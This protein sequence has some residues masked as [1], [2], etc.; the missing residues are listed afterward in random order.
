[1]ET[2]CYVL[3]LAPQDLVGIYKEKDNSEKEYILYVDYNKTTE[4][5]TD[6]HVLIYLANTNFKTSFDHV[7]TGLV[8]EFIKTN[9]IVHSPMLSRIV[10]M[11]LKVY[12]KHELTDGEK[13]LTTSLFTMEQINEFIELNGNLIE[14]LIKTIQ[15]LFAFTLWKLHSHIEDP[16]VEEPTLAEYVKEIEVVDHA[17]N[18]GPNI[19]RLVT[20]AIDV[21]YLVFHVRGVSQ[22]FNKQVYND[23]PKYQ[24]TDLFYLMNQTKVVNLIMEMLPEDFWHD[25]KTE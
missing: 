13:L 12:L 11:I 14:D 22:V 21:L 23:N 8:K 24:G 18:I 10:A 3:P 4:K 20:E 1:M 25:S 7:S 6:Q 5:L 19:A 9:F 2:K 16:S 17:T 15:G